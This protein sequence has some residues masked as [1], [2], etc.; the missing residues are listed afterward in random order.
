M[1]KVACLFLLLASWSSLPVLALDN[2]S[3]Q[4]K[5]THAFQF[6]GYYAAKEKGFYQEAGLAV[7]IIEATPGSDPVNNV[8]SG[9][10]EYGIGTS[11]L[12]LLRNAGKPVVVLGVIFQHSPYILLSRQHGPIQSIHDLDGKRVMLEPQ[13]EELLAYLKMEGIPFDRITRVEHSFDPQDLVTGKV[14]AISAYAINQPYYLDRSHFNYQTYS[15]RS[16]GI[17]FYGDNL[18]TTEQEL[19]LHPE[20]VRAFRAAS[21]RGWQYAMGHPEEIA[22]LIRAKYTQQH[23]RDYLLFQA[24]Q[25]LPLIRPELIEIGYMYP[26]RWR[27]IAETYVELGMLTKDF[28]LDGFLYDPKPNIDLSWLYRLL[29]GALLLI[30]ILIRFAWI[31]KKLRI[32]EQRY[33]GLFS[34]MTNGFALHELT[35]DSTGKPVGYD[36]LEVNPVFEKMT[37]LSREDR[38]GKRVRDVLPNLRCYWPENYGSVSVTGDSQY[39]EDYSKELD[40]WFATYSYRPGDKQFAVILQDISERK[41][42]E[43]ALSGA[44]IQLQQKLDQINQLQDKLRDQAMRDALTGLYN[45]RYLDETL[46]RELARAKREACP[47]CVLM[48]D[49]DHFK[50]VNDTHGHQAGDDVLKMFSTLLRE[51][52]RAEDI[53]CRYGGEEF[54]LLLPKMPLEVARQR[55]E[56]LRAEFAARVVDVGRYSIR[57]T[58]SV[59]IAVFPDHGSLPDELTRNADLALY[60]AKQNGRNCVV[61]HAPIANPS[62]GST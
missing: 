47:L 31:S 15:P 49:L 34:H 12:L 56:H 5:W 21:Q 52:A 36:F 59:G 37:G 14:D 45:R 4:L 8:L 33:R 55:A 48:I 54:L 61:I 39:F 16:A 26:G 22:D 9:Q 41:R 32:S 28:S 38:I 6:A 58:L 7:N 30:V 23:S 44:N 27:H 3:L 25:M 50:Q 53:P 29:A 62:H 13:A 43:M 17:D 10:A 35:F 46:E 1:R 57:E 2:V 40:Q 42:T 60:Q 19:K 20:R 51:S 18:F 24:K 11:S